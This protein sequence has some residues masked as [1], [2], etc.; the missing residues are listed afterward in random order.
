MIVQI[1]RSAEADQGVVLE[2]AHRFLLLDWLAQPDL[3]RV[4]GPVQRLVVKISADRRLDD[5]EV[6]GN[7]EVPWREQ[8]VV[9]NMKDLLDASWAVRRVNRSP[10]GYR[11]N[12][13]TNR[14][15]CLG[16]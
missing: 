8:A 1:T 5:L 15:K 12:W 14:L 9:S 10:G 6:R 11:E 4:D 7:I 3:P 13:I 16:D 2:N